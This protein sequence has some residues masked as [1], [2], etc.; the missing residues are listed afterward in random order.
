MGLVLM[1]LVFVAFV[2]FFSVSFSRIFS[3]ALF[4]TFD[5]LICFLV[6]INCGA[7]SSQNC[8]YFESSGVTAGNCRATICPCSDT[9]CQVI[10]QRVLEWCDFLTYRVRT[11]RKLRHYIIKDLQVKF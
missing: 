10:R 3:K 1:D 11:I 8:T 6:S 4:I 7:R 5:S 9:I 2:S